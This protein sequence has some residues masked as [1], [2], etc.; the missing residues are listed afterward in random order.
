MYRIKKR[1]DDNIINNSSS[2]SKKI[3]IDEQVTTALATNCT[4]KWNEFLTRWPSGESVASKISMGSVGISP[5]ESL[6][7]LS[8][9]CIHVVGHEIVKDS[10]GLFQ[11]SLCVCD[12]ES[13][14]L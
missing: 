6:R 11:S 2:S 3:Y 5:K 14:V 12:S 9:W 10:L 13:N 4:G 8:K 1:N 7:I